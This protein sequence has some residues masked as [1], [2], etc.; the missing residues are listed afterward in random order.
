[1]PIPRIPDGTALALTPGQ[2]G[3]LEAFYGA[4][5]GHD[6]DLLDEATTADWEDIP[7]APGQ[8]PGPEGAKPIFRMLL[9]AFPDLVVDI[10]DVMAER[11]RAAVR[12]MVSATHVGPLFGVPA[13]GRRVTF[14]LHEFHDFESDRLRRTWH[15]EDLFGLFS[16]VG[17]FPALPGETA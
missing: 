3:A 15:L 9:T 8:G 2:H 16:Q 12:A 7:L 10:V 14:A 11:D 1:M 13:S 17:A 5:G 6:V 4:L